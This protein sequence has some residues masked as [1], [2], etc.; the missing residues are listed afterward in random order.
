MPVEV[1]LPS[2][3]RIHVQGQSSL[4]VKGET[5]GEV[6]ENLAKENPGM[7]G[8]IVDGEG[9]LRKFVNVYVNDDDIRY[10]N[11]LDTKL[12]SGDVITILP[13]VAGGGW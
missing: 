13:A 10:L 7:T 8:Q 6:L 2:M 9:V 3:L 1:R 5:V 12:S 11:Q 4:E